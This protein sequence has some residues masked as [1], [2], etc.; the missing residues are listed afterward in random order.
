MADLSVLRLLRN[1]P[2]AAAEM[3]AAAEQGD[4]DAQYAMGLIYAEGRGVAQD[5]VRAHYWLSRAIE[6][7]DAD[8]QTLLQIVAFNMTDAQFEQAGQLLDAYHAGDGPVER[9]PGRKRKD[10]ANRLRLH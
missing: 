5:E 10:R 8:A 1:D 2:E 7:G 6:Q 3:L 4:V 9:A